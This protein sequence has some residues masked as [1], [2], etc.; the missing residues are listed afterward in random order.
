VQE[1][2]ASRGHQ[3]GTGGLA[4]TKEI[5]MSDQAKTAQ[6]ISQ[7]AQKH[8]RIE[9][10]QVRHSDRLDFH[11]CGVASIEAALSAAFEAGKKAAGSVK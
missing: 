11:D 2:L 5:A 1:V 4:T 9:T 7:I 3:S 10:L 6:I 8:L